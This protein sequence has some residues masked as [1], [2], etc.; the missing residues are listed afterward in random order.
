MLVVKNRGYK[1]KY[2]YGGSGIFETIGDFPRR[3]LGS[4][5]AK[6][7]AKQAAKRVA[8]QAAS[9]ALDVG[10]TAAFTAS[11]QAHQATG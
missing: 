5:V 2:I 8:K 7:A 3:V 11:K 6:Q 9:V 4:T 1:R 10:K